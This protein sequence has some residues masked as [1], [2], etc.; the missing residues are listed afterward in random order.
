MIIV[1]VNCHFA[2]SGDALVVIVQR[3][4]VVG[5]CEAVHARIIRGF[6]FDNRLTGVGQAV[7]ATISP[8]H[9]RCG[10]QRLVKIKQRFDLRRRQ[11]VAKALRFRR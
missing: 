9:V 8:I 6:C 3:V 1:G 2:N 10:H 11:Q 5:Q 4:G 7:I